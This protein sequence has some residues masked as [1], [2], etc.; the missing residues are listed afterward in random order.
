MSPANRREVLEFY[1]LTDPTALNPLSL[2]A[3]PANLV[4]HS[5]SAGA[6]AT[7]RDGSQCDD[8]NPASCLSD[9]PLTNFNALQAELDRVLDSQSACPGDGNLDMRV[10]QRDADG[11]AAFAAAMSPLTGDI[12]G[13]SF[14]DLNG[15]ARTDDADAAIVAAHMGTD[16]L[17]PCRRSDLNRDGYVDDTDAAL[18]EQASGPC[19]LCGADLNDDGVVDGEDASI[20]DDQRGCSMPTPTPTPVAT[21]QV[22]PR[23]VTPIEIC[24]E[25]CIPDA[26]ERQCGCPLFDDN[27]AL[28]P[29][30]GIDCDL[31]CEEY[32]TC[33]QN[34]VELGYTC[35]ATLCTSRQISLVAEGCLGIQQC[36]LSETLRAELAA[37]CSCCASQLCGCEASAL[38]DEAVRLLDERQREAGETPQCDINGTLCGVP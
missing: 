30:S 11:V 19:D 12:G 28:P 7:C 9:G 15:D 6:P 16:C 35:D 13:P 4:C 24:D 31:V 29:N 8:S 34:Q 32:A 20:L 22:P 3:G 21:K 23:T 14:F 26:V 38:T 27:T 5:R 37:G 10:D 25:V 33:Q 1:D 18:L 36:D 17:G 2:D